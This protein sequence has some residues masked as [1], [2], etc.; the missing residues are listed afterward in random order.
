MSVKSPLRSR[1]HPSLGLIETLR[2]EP[3]IGCIRMERHLARMVASS[4]HFGKVLDQA[5]AREMLNMIAAQTPL[6]IRLYL[7]ETDMLSCTAHPF[8]PVAK[9]K[10]WTVA[11]AAA[12]L[13]SLNANLAHK[14]SLR[15]IYDQARA[16]F[17]TSEVDEVLLENEHGHLCEG[18]ITSLFVKRD[19]TL[20]TPPLTEGLL[21]GILRE[22]LLESGRAIEG[23]LTRKDL[24]NGALY[25]GN[26]LRGLIPAR[27]IMPIA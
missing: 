9:D 3:N 8:V 22:E 20:I 21:R 15:T 27:L 11:I 25:V 6:R 12:K 14:T 4:A 19:A 2:Y 18:T 23:V 5:N 10:I 1:N 7:D 24:L 26:S 16:E 13:V 17:P